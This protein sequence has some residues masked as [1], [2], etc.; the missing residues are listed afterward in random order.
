MLWSAF[1]NEEL[2][3]LDTMFISVKLHILIIYVNQGSRTFDGTEI[4]EPVPG[5]LA[6]ETETNDSM[7]DKSE[8]STSNDD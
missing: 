7:E 6:L 4:E 5:Q 8:D 2:R 1:L 3:F